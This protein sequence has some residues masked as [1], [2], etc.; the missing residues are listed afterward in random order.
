MQATDNRAFRQWAPTGSADVLGSMHMGEDCLFTTWLLWIFAATYRHQRH[1]PK[2]AC[3]DA[4]RARWHIQLH[5]ICI[6]RNDMPPVE[7]QSNCGGAARHSQLQKGALKAQKNKTKN[8]EELRAG[9]KQVALPIER[10]ERATLL[11]HHRRQETHC[12]RE[13]SKKCSVQKTLSLLYSVHATW[14]LLWGTSSQPR[15]VLLLCCC[16]ATHGAEVHAADWPCV[17]ICQAACAVSWALL[18]A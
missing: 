11:L 4:G 14:L 12:T 17:S 18:R 1:K 5:C 8:A 16:C 9:R 6:S 10:L 13:T 7:G 15:D 3:G 2:E